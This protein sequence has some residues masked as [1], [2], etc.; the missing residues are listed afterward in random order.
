MGTFQGP[1]QYVTKLDPTGSKL[2]FS[3]A[4]SGTGNT[5]NEGLTVDAGGNVYLTGLAAVGYPFTVVS[6]A[7]TVKPRALAALATPAP[8]VSVQ[9][10]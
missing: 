9:A 5:V 2:I 10:L 6:S 4:V 3:T 1:N 7:R 8:T